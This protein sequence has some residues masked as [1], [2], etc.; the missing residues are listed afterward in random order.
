MSASLSTP[1]NFTPGTTKEEQLKLTKDG[2]DV[3][4]D[5]PRY[6]KEGVQ[7][8]EPD[9]FMR[10]KWYGVYQQKPKEDG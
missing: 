4:Q 3:I 1:R 9:D 10:F 5:L 2:L 7:A 6:A 8:I